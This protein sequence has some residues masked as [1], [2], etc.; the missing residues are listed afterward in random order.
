MFILFK[1]VFN[2]LNSQI[3]VK[4][5]KKM[6]YNLMYSSSHITM[7]TSADDLFD[8][9]GKKVDGIFRKIEDDTPYTEGY[10]RNGNK[11]DGVLK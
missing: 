8:K 2:L 10:D 1:Y 7:G 9:S 6:N 4:L 5:I 11:L 3:Y